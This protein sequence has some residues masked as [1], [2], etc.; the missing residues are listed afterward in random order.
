MDGS[1]YRFAQNA[2][3]NLD[4]QTVARR[5]ER[6]T[7]AG[8]RIGRGVS[9]LALSVYEEALARAAGPKYRLESTVY[10]LEVRDLDH[11]VASCFDYIVTSSIIAGRFAEGGRARDG[12]PDSARFYDS[13]EQDAR[14]TL[15]HE[16]AP[17]PWRKSGPVIRVYRITADNCAHPAE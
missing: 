5:I 6:V 4:E 11:Y 12:F 13:L 7:E 3:L 16:E 2:P 14:V 8:G 10:G 15:V 17:V 1:R 9:P